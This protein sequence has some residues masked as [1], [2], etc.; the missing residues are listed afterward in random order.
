MATKCGETDATKKA[1]IQRIY[2]LRLKSKGIPTADVV[3]IALFDNIMDHLV[4][5]E[6]LHV[7]QHIMARVTK[8]LLDERPE[9]TR[10]GVSY[11][12]EHM[13]SK[14]NNRISE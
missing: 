14:R 7:R 5:P 13:F 8:R 9:L 2:R 11:R 1:E 4:G 10:S 12:I 6:S 3:A